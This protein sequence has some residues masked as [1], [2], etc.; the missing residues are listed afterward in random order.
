M[1]TLTFLGT[2]S[3]IPD[4]THENSHMVVTGRERTILIDSVGNSILRLKEA[5]VD[6]S[7]LT[8]LIVTHFHPDH[9]SGVP[10]LLMNMWLLGRRHGLNIYCL[11]YTI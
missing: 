1:P 10:S 5:G 8:D 3:A 11:Q 7:N 4:E 2:S 6:H 9:V